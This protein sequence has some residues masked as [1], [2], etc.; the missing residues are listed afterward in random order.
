MFWWL[1]KEL[2]QLQQHILLLKHAAH[3]HG[4]EHSSRL[5]T[6]LYDDGFTLPDDSNKTIVDTDSSVHGAAETGAFERSHDPRLAALP[7]DIVGETSSA[8]EVSQ[9]SHR[10]H[11]QTQQAVSSP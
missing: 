1:Q 8:H 11:H 2:Q 9:H 4:I 6:M 3:Q 10:T 5:G 7:T